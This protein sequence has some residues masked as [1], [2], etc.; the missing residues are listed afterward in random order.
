MNRVRLVSLSVL[1]AF[2][3]ACTLLGDYSSFTSLEDENVG[4]GDGDTGGGVGDGDGDGDGDTGGNGGTGGADGT[5]GD[6]GSGG[7]QGNFCDPAVGVSNPISGTLNQTNPFQR[8]AV[9]T[10]AKQYYVQNNLW[11][12]PGGSFNM[13]YE[14]TAFTINNQAGNV[15]TAGPPVGY[16]SLFIGSSGGD[17]Q[18][19]SGSNLPVQVS[20]ISSIPTGWRWT[21]ASSGVYTVELNAWFS[22]TA[23]DAGAASRSHLQVW[24]GQSGAVQPFGSVVATVNLGGRSYQVYS[25]LDGESRPIVTYS[26]TTQVTDAT[27]DLAAFIDDAVSRS[28]LSNNLYLTNIFAGFSIWSGAAGLRTDG[29]CVSVE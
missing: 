20:A 6:P 21:P 16:P 13:S 27:F 7:S 26:A 11:N 8:V 1:C 23:G 12:W 4:D 25:G 15:S 3:S 10:G 9:N 28:S 19:T 18:A 2:A 5:G 29:F 14:G 24:L 22:T 17:G